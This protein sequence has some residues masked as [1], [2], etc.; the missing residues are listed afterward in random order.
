VLAWSA[1]GNKWQPTAA[2]AGTGN[3][4]AG[5]TLTNNAIVLGAGTTA[6]AALGSLGTTT[7]L[8]HGNAAGGPTFGAASLTA[9]VSGTLP[10]GNG[11]TGATAL[12]NHGVVTAGA[13]ALTTVAPGTNGNVLTSNGTDWTSAAAPA[14]ALTTTDGTHSVTSTTTQTF[15][16]GF[17][18]GGSAG[19]ATIATTNTLDTQSGTGAFAIPSAD[20]GAIIVRTNASGG[21]DTI[22]NATGAFGAG[23]GTTYLTSGFAG[24]TITP[25]TAKI[26][27]LTA[28]K[29]GSYQAASIASNGTNYYASL[30]VPQPATQTG[31]TFLKDDMTWAAFGA[32]ATTTPGT[33]VA[34]AAAA[35]LSAA[36]GL[37]TTVASGTSA[38]GTSAISSATCATVVTTAATGTATTDVVTASFNGDPTAVTGFIPSASGMLSIISYPSSNNV[39]FKVCNNTAGSITPGA[40]TLNW[41]VV[42]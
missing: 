27:N 18:V 19:S 6:V 10:F 42:R 32:L 24:N 35:N 29:L 39:N 37:T 16:N 20:G 36:G 41:R 22:A 30:S 17:L 40:I 12:T 33:G 21:A 7:T 23:Y 9:D 2:G 38:L 8:L 34:T 5:G 4:T 14:G 13:S 1:S 11:G 31:T 26:N 3:V 15:G 28:L 25:T